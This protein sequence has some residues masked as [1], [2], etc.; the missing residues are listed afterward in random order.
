MK[1]IAQSLLEIGAV[2]LSPNEPFTWA[3]GLKSPIYCDNRKALSHVGV[4][5][6]IVDV[7]MQNAGEFNP[8][9][10]VGVATGADSWGA[11]VSVWGGSSEHGLPFAYVRSK[12]KD[13][14]LGHQIEGDL[15][16]GCNVVVVEDLISTGGSSLKAVRALREAG[17]NVLGMVAIFTYQFP[18]AEKAFHE[19]G[20]QLLTATNYSELVE[21]AY[22]EG[23][24][25]APEMELLG[26]WRQDHEHW[27]K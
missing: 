21:V 9:A 7:L 26:A 1:K 27:G 13:H 15:P 11:Y 19:A 8:Q 20:V 18:E 25:G 6:E 16:K 4:R 3:S 17:F 24:F 10:I 14:G 22:N 5:N 2:Q 12:P 23:R